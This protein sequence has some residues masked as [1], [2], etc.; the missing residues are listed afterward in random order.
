[1]KVTSEYGQ[2]SL[3]SIGYPSAPS[4]KETTDKVSEE[5]E[6]ETS[7]W[8]EPDMD[9]LSDSLKSLSANQS[10]QSGAGNFKVKSSSPDDSV[11]ELASMLAR[12]ETRMDVQQVASK[13]M[14]A[15]ANLKMSAVASEGKDAKKIAQMIKRMEK[16]IK[17]IQKKLQH[18]S[19]EEQLELREKKLEKEQQAEKAEEGREQLK[20]RRKRR[21]KDE[22]EY[23]RKEMGEDAKNAISEMVS[24]L[25]DAISSSSST[26]SPGTSPAPVP[27]I[28]S[29]SADMAAADM[30]S[31]DIS[32]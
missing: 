19:K 31:I 5:P 14:R 16:L 7:L 6:K 28:S 3:R 10:D 15:L 2:Q 29:M 17:R 30:V 8:T 21:K 12:A 20:A 27:D 26:V 32:V 13:A 25:T 11:G 23:A 22:Q 1:M 4:S 24:G 18:L 9:T